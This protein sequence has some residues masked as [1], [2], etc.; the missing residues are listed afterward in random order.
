MTVKDD[1]AE[2]E[3]SRDALRPGCGERSD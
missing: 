2:K 1:E 3:N